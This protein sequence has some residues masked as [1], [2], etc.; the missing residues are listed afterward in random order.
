[1]HSFEITPPNHSIIAAEQ[2]VEWFLT[3]YLSDYEIDL[4]VENTDLSE[5]GGFG[6]CLRN[7]G[8]EFTIQVHFP[9]KEPQYIMTLM[10]ELFHVQQHL[11][12]RDRNEFEAQTMEIKLFNEYLTHIR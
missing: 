12:G 9:L 7:E 2:V 4:T 8:N 6:W 11:E 10:H 3:K 5:D 1:M